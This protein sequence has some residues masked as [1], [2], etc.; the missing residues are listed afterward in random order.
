MRT[1]SPTLKSFCQGANTSS[2]TICC[3]PCLTTEPF[4]DCA[5]SIFFFLIQ[6][7]GWIILIRT[8]Y[9]IPTSLCS[10]SRNACSIEVCISSSQSSMTITTTSTSSI[11]KA[12]TTNRLPWEIRV[13]ATTE[14]SISSDLKKEFQNSPKKSLQIAHILGNTCLH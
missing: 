4:K 9:Q 8:A 12:S 1:H 5:A 11:T 6:L 3:P 2:I 10:V 13:W 7:Y 14:E